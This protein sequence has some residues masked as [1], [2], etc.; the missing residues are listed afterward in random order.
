M[1]TIELTT[2]ILPGG[3]IHIPATDLPEGRE[4]TVRIEVAE[5]AP[6]PAK[7]SFLENLGSYEGGRSFK[8]VEEVDCY[9]K[10]ERDSWGD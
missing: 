5:E 3:G 4:A 10:E 1:P 2:R 6:P 7:R 9:I 8:T